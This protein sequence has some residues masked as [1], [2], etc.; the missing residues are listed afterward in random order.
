VPAAYQV[1]REPTSG[2]QG[3]PQPQFDPFDEPFTDDSAAMPAADPQLASPLAAAPGHVAPSVDDRD[4]HSQQRAEFDPFDADSVATAP[5]AGEQASLSPDARDARGGPRD[6]GEQF[7]VQNAFDEPRRPS[8][9]PSLEDQLGDAGN[10]VDEEIH[11]R[12][13]DGPAPPSPGDGGAN[14]FTP[15]EAIDAPQRNPEEA[16][17]EPGSES[18]PGE[19]NEPGRG[20][21][22]QQAPGGYQFRPLDDQP[23]LTPE[24]QEQHR[25]VLEKE[26][27]KSEQTCQEFLAAVQADDIKTVSLDIRMH[28]QAGEDYPFDCG[29][30][31]SQF[32]PRSW[33]QVTYMWKASGLCHKPLYFEQVQM[34]R[35]GHSWGPILDPVMSGA[36]FFTTFPILPYKMGLMTPNECVYTLGY[37]RPGSCAPYMVEPLGFTWR[38]AAFEMGA[39]T[40][41][42]FAIP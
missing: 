6:R 36:H 23:A 29:L 25:Q 24:Q 19:D 7:D 39:W 10:A 17:P 27:Q 5:P 35:Y 33:P 8:V 30:G 20:S 32:V 26:R 42:A 12:E 14:P 15:D 38:A 11:R 41:G 18:E 21:Q 34:E 2:P 9:G 28:G 37:Y 16:F 13:N 31:N 3:S 40:G 4:D 22:Y 1:R